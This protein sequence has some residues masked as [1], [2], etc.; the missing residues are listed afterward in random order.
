MQQI[1]VTYKESSSPRIQ[2]VDLL[3][4]RN[5]RGASHNVCNLLYRISKTSWK[6]PVV[7]HNLEGYEGHLIV[8]ALKSEFWKVRVI[9]ENMEKYLSL[10][11]G[12]LK[13]ID[14]F[15]FTPQGLDKLVKTLGVDEFRYLSESCISNH[16]GLIHC[17]GV[18]PYDYMDSCDR[19]EET[20]LPS[21]DAF[22]SKSSGSPCSDSEYTHAT[23]VWD[24]FRC[25]TIADYHGIY[26]QLDVLLLKK[27]CITCL[28]SYSLDPLHYKTTPGHAWDVICCSA[29]HNR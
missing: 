15:Q 10:L 29:V 21:Q 5:Y 12:Q 4:Y 2:D 28:E 11:V 14:S 17:K 16:F 1:A 3:T 9:P 23:R 26:L 19:F 22:F 24:A 8:K 6:L 7:I 18:D 20:E 25:K 27:F 13:L